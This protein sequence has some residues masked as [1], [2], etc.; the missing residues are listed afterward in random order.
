MPKRVDHRQRRAE[1][2]QA[3]WRVA[4]YQG[5]E[6]VSLS[7][8]AE[9]AGVSK[10]RVQH[11]FPSRDSLLNYTAVLVQD[12]VNAR[13]REYVSQACGPMASTRAALFAVLPLETESAIDTRVGFAFFIRSLGDPELRERYRAR[14][15]EF[16]ELI[17]S[18][19]TQARTE[20]TLHSTEDAQDT[21]RALFALVN[22]LKEPLLLGE[23]NPTEATAIIEKALQTLSQRPMPNDHHIALSRS[24]TSTISASTASPS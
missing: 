7:R 2:A 15:H 4:A 16:I 24:A 1:M 23:Q 18:H 10:G 5:L 6:A 11:Y 21:A 20:G 9:E 19:L 13:I 14:N 3:L 12:R 22:G 8:V 17:S